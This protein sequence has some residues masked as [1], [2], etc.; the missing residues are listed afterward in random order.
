MATKSVIPFFGRAWSLTIIPDAGPLANHPIVISTDTFGPEALRIEFEI[1]QMAFE[2]FWQAEFVIY[3][4]DGIIPGT[5]FSLYEAVIQE[6]D[7]VIFGAG[8]QADV[9]DGG[10]PPVIWD[11]NI[12]YTT[13]D[14]LDVVDK[15]L[16]IHCLINRLLTT[17][18]FL[19]GTLPARATQFTQAQFIAQNST[20]PIKIDQNM[21]DQANANSGISRGANQLPRAK[22]YFGNPHHYLAALADQND[23]QSWFDSRKW[24]VD[25]LRN[26]TGPIVGTYAPLYILNG[27]P[28]REGKVSFSL[29]GQPQQTTLGVSFRVLLD[30]AVQ[31]TAPL[32]QVVVQ[33]Q[34]VKQAPI[35]YPPQ[36]N[37]FPPRPL[38]ETDQ[39]VVIGVRFVGDTR[40]NPWYTE[41]TGAA[42]VLNAVQMLGYRKES[43]PNHT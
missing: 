37:E 3:N 33:K 24:N 42:N 35:N 31:I 32:S 12:F 28:V 25:S 18:N 38:N 13:Q 6:G 40:G 2:G 43:D 14:R 27:P 30:P 39:Y 34:Y 29:I 36:Q 16:I 23:L 10:K 17:K 15:R 19:K 9:P 20:N 21:W 8:Y 1:V 11:G 5:N 7:E 26:P 22:T 4:A 41:V